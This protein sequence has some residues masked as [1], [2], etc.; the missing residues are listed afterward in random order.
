[1]IIDGRE[2]SLVYDVNMED[3]TYALRDVNITLDK[4]GMTGIIG[5]SGSGKS[6]LLY[7]LAGLKSPTSGTVY[8]DD[9][10]IESLQPA[11]MDSIRR[12]KFGFIFQ[13]HFLIDYLSVLDN[14][15][16]GLN[17]H[18]RD[19]IEK[20][21]L[22]LGK[23]KIARLA[24]KKPYQLSVGQR[25]RVAVARALINDPSVIFA[26]EPTASLD[27]MNATEVMR[28]LEEFKKKASILVVTHDRSILDKADHIIQLWDGKLTVHPL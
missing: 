9:I 6:S 2:L 11:A 27:H 19:S 10:D 8:Y 12:N 16:V 14:V 17:K 24:N 20:A 21:M 7:V 15:L 22:L 4:H 23:F 13:K 25:Q 3:E 1:M 28:V 5:P 18:D 26:D